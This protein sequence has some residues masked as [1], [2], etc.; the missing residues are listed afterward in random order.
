M[1]LYVIA[2]V[3]VLALIVGCRTLE[4]TPDEYKAIEIEC[5]GDAICMMVE[6]EQLLDEKREQMIYERE[7]R[8][9]RER[10][11]IFNLIIVCEATNNILIT[12]QHRRTIRRKHGDPFT[13]DDIPK[14]AHRGDYVCVT[15]ETLRQ[16]LRQRAERAI[17]A[18]KPPR[19]PFRYI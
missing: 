6:E 16:I 10:E 12:K 19:S 1:R 18:V 11:D 7:D 13:M 15:P 9:L 2:F 8:R 14:N 4:V 17:E 5:Q 3:S